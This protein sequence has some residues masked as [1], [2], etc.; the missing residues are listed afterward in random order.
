MVATGVRLLPLVYQCVQA[1]NEG[2]GGRGGGET[3]S[4]GGGGRV[5]SVQL[6]GAA[7]CGE[8]QAM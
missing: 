4:G 5:G 1:A 2:A 8:G 6:D 3:A 7:D